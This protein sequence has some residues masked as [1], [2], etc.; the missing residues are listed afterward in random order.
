MVDAK[1]NSNLTRPY[2]MTGLYDSSICYEPDE[3]LCSQENVFSENS[4]S[5]WKIADLEA[6]RD[7]PRAIFVEKVLELTRS[8][9]TDLETMKILLFKSAKARDD[10]PCKEGYLKRRLETRN[11]AGIPLEKKL[12]K[13]CFVMY[14]ASEGEYD[15]D[16]YDVVGIARGKKKTTAIPDSE[17]SSEEKRSHETILLLNETVAKLAR[18][19]HLLKESYDCDRKEM[20]NDIKSIGEELNNVKQEN[21]KMKRALEKKSK[22]KGENDSFNKLSDRVKKAEN[23][24]ERLKGS[25]ALNKSE[26]DATALKI[27]NL[28]IEISNQVTEVAISSERLENRHRYVEGRLVE[29]R[30][31]INEI[32]HK[33][34]DCETIAK[35]FDNDQSN[36]VASLKSGV[37]VMK[38]TIQ[39]LENDVQSIKDSNTSCGTIVNNVTRDMSVIRDDVKKLKNSVAQE[40]KPAQIEGQRIPVTNTRASPA[41]INGNDKQPTAESMTQ[42]TMLRDIPRDRGQSIEKRPNN[43]KRTESPT[44]HDRQ[45]NSAITENVAERTEHAN[46]RRIPVVVSTNFRVDDRATIAGNNDVQARNFRG[47]KPKRK[48][49][50]VRYYVGGINKR[51]TEKDMR[52]FL[53]HEQIRVTFLRFFCRDYRRSASAQLNIHPDDEEQVLADDFWPAGI[54]IKPWLPWA[55]FSENKREYN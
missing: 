53:L 45:H 28:R 23:E 25:S 16:L 48:S 8:D 10:F 38:Q 24:I 55:V 3:Q 34:G 30:T 43:E 2:S 6:F 49:N 35:R 27:N 13:D 54:F 39:S 5:K 1:Q 21:E 12:A 18:D 19:M 14:R 9:I 17:Q 46:G 22:H 32:G 44:S 29:L 31:Q 47:V 26:H 20:R 15:H 7:A 52:D 11:R 37:K 36:G 4:G 41:K 33:I 42:K 51:S 40:K 50:A